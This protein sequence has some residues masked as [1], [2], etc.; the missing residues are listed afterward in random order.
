MQIGI[1]MFKKLFLIIDP[2]AECDVSCNNNA[3]KYVSITDT[4]S[5]IVLHHLYKYCPA[6]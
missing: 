3:I 1:E 5:V 4:D 2:T 6:G